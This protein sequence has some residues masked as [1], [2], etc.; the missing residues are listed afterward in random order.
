[1]RKMNEEFS[2]EE[3]NRA[4]TNCRD[5]SSPGMD[6]IE[7]KMIKG[8]ERGHR[9]ILLELFNHSFFTG[10]L[11]KD[12]KLNQTIFIDKG[13]KIKVRP[14]TMSSCMCKIMERLINERLIWIAESRGW[15]N[16][17]QNGFRKG[18]SC[19]DNLTRIT[20]DVEINLNEGGKVLAAFLDVKSAYD[21]VI[22]NVLIDQ[23]IR[24]G[25]PSNMVRFIQNWIRDRITKF[26]VGE[27]RD[28]MCVVNKGLPQG[29]VINPILYSIYT[30]DITVRR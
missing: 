6:A 13:N 12:W 8:L 22:G 14:I 5:K 26:I 16:K 3:L 7:Y 25:C 29:G 10:H 1:M 20:A 21:N 27:G 24:K 23:L 18:R 17:T 28:Y 4:I 11:Y 15:L 2:M 30:A 9:L 19:L